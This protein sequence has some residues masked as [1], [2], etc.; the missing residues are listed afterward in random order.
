MIKGVIFD[1]N[2]TLSDDI[3][4]VFAVAM[5]TSARLG[6]KQLS[7]SE[8]RKKVRNPY[9][10]FYRDL[11]CAASKAEINRLY[12]RYL[13]Q[14]RT[15]VSLFPD[16]TQVLK[17]LDGQGIKV[18]IISSHPTFAIKA[19]AKSY[20]ISRYIDFMRGDIHIKG[21][22][23]IAFLKRFRIKPREA[24]FVGDMVND[25]E[26]GK[27]C[28]VITAAYLKGVDSKEKLLKAKPDILLP[29]LLALKK[30]IS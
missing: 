25:I 20:G 2:G 29:N 23:I 19:E 16:A 17:L 8:Y 30:F 5:K 27:K 6:G 28:G 4:K 12:W 11:G 15:P 7:Y 22:H 13:K 21:Y 3:P 26:E 9:L 24:I 14:D 10:L 18:G 1:W